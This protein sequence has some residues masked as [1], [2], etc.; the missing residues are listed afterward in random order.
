KTSTQQRNRYYQGVFEQLTQ[1]A[2]LGKPIAGFNFW[3]W[4]GFG[5]S[6]R[7]DFIWRKGD[8][9]T[10]D[11]PQEPQGL[12]S[13]FASDQSTLDIIKKAGLDFYRAP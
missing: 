11:P 7:A 2:R 10:G 1:Q 6:Q 13:V 4:G 9:F 5:H 12:N 8:D 3:A